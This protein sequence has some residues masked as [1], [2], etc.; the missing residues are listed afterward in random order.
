MTSTQI[1]YLVAAACGICALA[2]FVALI[3]FPAWNAYSKTWER[4]AA[5]FLSVFVLVALIVLGA[6]GG[7]AIAY[8]WDSIAA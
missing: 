2:A 8:Y 6:L 4:V 3:A 5:G 1:T 7:A